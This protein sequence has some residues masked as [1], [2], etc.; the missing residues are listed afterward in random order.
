MVGQDGPDTENSGA[1]YRGCIR[2]TSAFME[3]NMD[4]IF[5]GIS[6]AMS[7]TCNVLRL[8]AQIRY[9]RLFCRGFQNLSTGIGLQVLRAAA[10]AKKG[11]PAE[12]ILKDNERI[13]GKVR[14]SF[15]GGYAYLPP[16]R[17][18][19]SGVQAILANTLRLKPE[20]VVKDG[21]MDVGKKYRGNIK[22]VLM[23]YV[24]DRKDQLL[25]ADR[26]GIYHAFG[27]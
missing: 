11:A 8:V 13:N 18:R 15:C 7:A 21:R 25:D 19:C 26:A 17:G 23:K 1:H 2:D 10:M 24:E 14:A 9:D 20:I 27:L 6:E 16:P 22:S 12:E 3:Q 5:F 4:I